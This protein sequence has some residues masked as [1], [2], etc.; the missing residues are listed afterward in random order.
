MYMGRAINASHSELGDD[1]VLADI[2]HH[3]IP[4]VYV[5][6]FSCLAGPLIVAF[7]Y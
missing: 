2:G 6:P 3:I 1:D 5:V 4:A 7:L